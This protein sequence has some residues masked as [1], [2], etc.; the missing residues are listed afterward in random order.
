M[1]T[2]H[3]FTL[4]DDIRK[5][6]LL[7]LCQIGGISDVSSDTQRKNGTIF[8]FDTESKVYYGIYSS[9]YVRRIVKHVG[10]NQMYQINPVIKV[11][12]PANYGN[13]QFI[14]YMVDRILFTDPIE[15]MYCCI[16]GILNRRKDYYR[17][18]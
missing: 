16:R 6:I 13:G 17:N 15:A 8:I 10:W 1:A 3:T 9:G 18:H 4:T 14:S 2:P 11:K 5:H 12:R 7:T